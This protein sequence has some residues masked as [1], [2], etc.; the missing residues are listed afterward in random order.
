MTGRKCNVRGCQFGKFGKPAASKDGP[1]ILH[2]HSRLCDTL[3]KKGGNGVLVKMLRN[4]ADGQRDKAMDLLPESARSGIAKILLKTRTKARA[5]DQE[6]VNGSLIQDDIAQFQDETHKV[7]KFNGLP[8]SST[9]SKALK[10]NETIRAIGKKTIELFS[11][12]KQHG[13]GRRDKTPSDTTTSKSSK[14]SKSSNSSA[15]D[16]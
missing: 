3:E 10:D 8:S 2:N 7:H 15:S 13:K 5:S 4:M 9:V 14:S 12:S 16:S 6:E 1:C 11:E